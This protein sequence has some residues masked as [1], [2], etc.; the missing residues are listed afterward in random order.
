MRVS[1]Q[2]NTTSAHTGVISIE[3]AKSTALRKAGLSSK[4]VVFSKGG[5]KYLLLTFDDVS[6]EELF[7]MAEEI[8]RAE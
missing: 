3:E 2:N 8:I 4:D 7:G 6:K 1:N 5:V